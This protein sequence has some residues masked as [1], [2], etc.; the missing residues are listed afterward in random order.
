MGRSSHFESHILQVSQQDSV[1]S[2]Y[3]VPDFSLLEKVK[4]SLVLKSVGGKHLT[5]P[6]PLLRSLNSTKQQ[7]NCELSPHYS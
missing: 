5:E 7:Q 3:S 4:H 1:F 6:F 2:I